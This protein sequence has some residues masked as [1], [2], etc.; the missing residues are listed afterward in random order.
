MLVL[1]WKPELRLRLLAKRLM[2][3]RYYD[4]KL[5]CYYTERLA[6]RYLSLIAVDQLTRTVTLNV[7]YVNFISLSESPR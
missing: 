1:G 6:M 7:T 3:E 5:S 4:N 2:E